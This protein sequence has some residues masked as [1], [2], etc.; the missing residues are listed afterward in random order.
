VRGFALGVLMPGPEQA[1]F[2]RRNPQ[3]FGMLSAIE[4]AIRG[5]PL[6]RGSGDHN[7]VEGRRR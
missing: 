4:G 1:G 3:I 5:W 2:A 6:L 7:V